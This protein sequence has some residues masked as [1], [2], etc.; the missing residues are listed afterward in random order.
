[1]R[2]EKGGGLPSS[3]GSVRATWYTRPCL[4][5]KESFS[6]PI[7][8]S[9]WK[10]GW[11]GVLCATSLARWPITQQSKGGWKIPC[12]GSL[13]F[14]VKNPIPDPLL[15]ISLYSPF[16]PSFPCYEKWGVVVCVSVCVWWGE[17]IG[18]WNGTKW[19]VLGVSAWHC[20]YRH[21]CMQT[22][23]RERGFWKRRVGS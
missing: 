8:V 19:H 17:Y 13:G 23:E 20:P 15:V 4:P 12:L 14:K 5:G 6:I 11:G 18:E 16:L 21:V 10:E 7:Y 22:S 1:M 2:E 3:W 9:W